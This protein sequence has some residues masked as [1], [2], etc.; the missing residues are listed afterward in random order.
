M[1]TTVHAA[2]KP[3][4]ARYLTSPELA[5]VTD[6]A[7]TCGESPADPFH[8]RVEPMDGCGVLVPVGTHA[9]VGGPHDAPTPGDILCAAL[10]ACQD[11][12]FRMVADL[13]G[14]KITQLEVKVSA[15]VDVRGTLA[16]DPM[17]PVG[18]QSISCDIRFAV[19][20]G[21]S[22]RLLQKLQVAAKQC[23]VVQQTLKAPPEVRTTFNN[24]RDEAVVRDRVANDHPV[25]DLSVLPV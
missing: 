21:T 20:D 13:I 12:T 22:P 23:C 6:H 16:M 2:Q 7:R 1:K 11:S 25:D 8:S 18:F 4:K 19:E 3:M 14:V 5:L 24:T 10:A 9:A 15:T 17:V